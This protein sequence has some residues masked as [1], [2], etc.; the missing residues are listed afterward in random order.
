MAWDDVWAFHEEGIRQEGERALQLVAIS[1]YPHNHDSQ[2]RKATLAMLRQ[3]AEFSWW[4]REDVYDTASPEER[5]RMIGS[6]VSF[7]GMEWLR[8]RPRHADWLNEHGVTAEQCVEEFWAYYLSQGGSLPDGG[9]HD[10]HV[11]EPQ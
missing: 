5:R 6:A 10:S 11:S 2:A 8:I 4:S 7:A 1:A 3:M 9:E